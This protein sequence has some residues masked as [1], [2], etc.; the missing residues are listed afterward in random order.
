MLLEAQSPP[1]AHTGSLRGKNPGN[2]ENER[3]KCSPG[4]GVPWPPSPRTKWRPGRECGPSAKTVHVPTRLEI[5]R[6]IQSRLGSRQGGPELLAN[7][8]SV[9]RRV[10]Q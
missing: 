1:A 4:I 7:E 6:V 2:I 9:G 3:A 8:N 10:S 5:F